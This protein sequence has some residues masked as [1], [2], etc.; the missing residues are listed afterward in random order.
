MR[1]LVVSS[2]DAIGGAAKAATR[3]HEA[4]LSVGVDST[5]L[6]QQKSSDTPSVVG[7]KSRL[8]KLL[9]TLRPAIEKLFLNAYSYKIKALF[10]P[11]MLPNAWLINEINS[12]KPDIVHLHWVADGMVRPEQFK[13]IDVPIVWSLHD[14]WPFTGGCHY[15][16]H[17]G[18]FRQGCGACPVLNSN[19]T[20]DLSR[21]TY[22]RKSRAYAKLN[23][24]T[25]V[26]LS[27][28]M[29]G[30]A[31]SSSLFVGRPVV[32]LPN[33]IDTKSFAPSDKEYA[34]KL[35]C[36]PTET[37]LVLFGAMGA[38]SDPRKGYAELT[39]ALKLLP[40]S[41]EVVVFGAREPTGSQGFLQ[42]AHYL[43]SFS[44]DISLRVIYS[45]CDVMVMPSIQENL[46]NAIMESMACGTPV[47]GF[48]I[49]GN[50]DLI[51]HKKNGY[52]AEPYCPEKLAE[53]I[54]WIIDCPEAP[55]LQ[56]NAVEKV[57]V[58]FDSKLVARRYKSLYRDL[59]AGPSN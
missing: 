56:A 42:K 51:D 13:K 26:G 15:D 28:W 47:V 52:L 25:I 4:L 55:E 41:Y 53:D 40:A 9:S 38:T 6:V 43:G 2:S 36:L 34:R 19:S 7:P 30:E 31:K 27:K 29:E 59:L 24:L 35:L 1:V 11:A 50:S 32:N 46:S 23:S 54:R 33:P 21:R 17:C 39:K 37:K 18:S 58:N 5:M 48:D 16:E 8:Q 22:E 10:S 3:L 14:M 49:G 44:D 12:I 57:R 20:R 45:A